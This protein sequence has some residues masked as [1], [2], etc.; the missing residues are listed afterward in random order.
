MLGTPFLLA[1]AL[2]LAGCTAAPANPVQTEET[3]AATPAPAAEEAEETAAAPVL[4]ELTP[5]TLDRY[6]KAS[7]IDDS[8][9]IFLTTIDLNDGRQRVA[10]TKPGC[11]HTGPD[12]WAWLQDSTVGRPNKLELYTDGEQLYWVNLTDYGH[13]DM[14]TID[15]QSSVFVSGLEGADAPPVE[16][17]AGTPNYGGD[18]LQDNSYMDS[19]WFTDGETLWA[20]INSNPPDETTGEQTFATTLIHFEPAPEGSFAPY[21]AQVVWRQVRDG[22]TGYAG[23][24]DGQIVVGVQYP[25]P[26]TGSMADNY[27]NSTTELRALGCDGI[28]G[29]PLARFV[30]GDYKTQA[31][32][33]GQWYT[34]AADSTD[35]QVTDL[36]TGESRTLCNLPEAAETFSVTPQFVYGGRLVVNLSRDAG[37]VRY[38]IDTETGAATTLPTTWAKDGAIP[39]VPVFYQ[40]AGDRCL[41]KVGSQDRMVTDMGQ[42]GGT[43]THPS[44]LSVYAV[45][46]LGAYLDGDQNWTICDLLTP[47]GVF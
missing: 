26:D 19:H 23:L 22:S 37:D 3:A 31:L 14:G 7:A 47:N 35:L 39:R 24:L 41:M 27:K 33:D 6:Y 46:D 25:G 11:A 40:V 44:S 16:W 32:V 4:R 28:L 17:L 21:T 36:H 8:S 18:F 5:C 13:Y 1:A 10:C 29:E 38:V 30:N 43:Y 15:P 12:C 45:E 42:D 2:L 20:L 9:Q 34:M